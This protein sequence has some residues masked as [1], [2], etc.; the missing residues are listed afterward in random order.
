[1]GFHGLC[2][3]EEVEAHLKNKSLLCLTPFSQLVQNSRQSGTPKAHA[4]VTCELRFHE[5]TVLFQI[6]LIFFVKLAIF[7]AKSVDFILLRLVLRFIHF[8]LF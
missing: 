3:A 5:L 4:V 8:V 7:V 6:L 1:M 2:L